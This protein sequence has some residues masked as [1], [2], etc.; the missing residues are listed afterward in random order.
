MN[1][2]DL[3]IFVDIVHH[4]FLQQSG[5][6]AQ[7]GTPFLSDAHAL[8]VFDFTGVIGITG[9]RQG[10]VYFTAPSALLQ[11]LLRQAGEPDLSPENLADLAGEIGNTLSGNARKSFG[12]TFMI[13]VPLVVEGREQVISLP[14]D[15]KSYVI[16]FRWR[17]H[18]ACLVVSVR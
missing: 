18:D 7:M 15:V 12:A 10:C 14:R 17:K 6:A 9:D 4:Y 2:S 8:P 11:D 1:E 13:S 5:K 3:K 16:P